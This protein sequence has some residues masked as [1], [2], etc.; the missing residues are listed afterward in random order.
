M[1]LGEEKDWWGRVKVAD[2]EG[3]GNGWQSINATA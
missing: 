2:S 1:G 3:V